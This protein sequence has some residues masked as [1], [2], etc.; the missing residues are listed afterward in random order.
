MKKMCALILALMLVLTGCA[1]KG[2]IK[3]ISVKKV[4]CPYEIKH[5]KD[6]VEI[7][8]RDGEKSGVLWAVDMI[9][10][11][12]CQVTPENTD[13]AYTSRYRLTGIEEGAAK[14]TFTA[15][16]PDETVCFVL[17]LIVDV[18]SKGKT[19]VSSCEHHERKENVVDEDGLNYTWNVDTEGILNFSFLNEE[20]KWSVRG[21]GEDVLTLTSA[22]ST[23]SGCSF[24]AQAKTEGQTTI[25]LFSKDAQRT[26][27]VVIEVDDDATMDVVSVQEQ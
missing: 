20:A 9:P 3:N 25:V 12:I 8:L 7:T 21:D 14:L 26:I 13:K 23:A 16:K 24:S 22:L 18:D 6:A 4:C 1:G 15:T 11:D 27:Y 2:R 19:V 5:K 17:D 10:E